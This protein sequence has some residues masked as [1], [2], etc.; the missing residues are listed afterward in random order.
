MATTT[1]TM[2]GECGRMIEKIY[3]NQYMVI[4]DNCQEGVELETWDECLTFMRENEWRRKLV[5]GHFHNYCPE[6]QEVE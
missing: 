1:R 6:C 4:C 2:E 5:N 3:K